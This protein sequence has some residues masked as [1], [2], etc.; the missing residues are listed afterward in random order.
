MKKYVITGAT[1]KIGKI[2]A[3]ELLAKGQNVTVIARNAGKLIFL[4]RLLK[5]LMRYSAF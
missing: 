3:T 4:H 5:V 2:V 1:G